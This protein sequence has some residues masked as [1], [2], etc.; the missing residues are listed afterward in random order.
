MPPLTLEQAKAISRWE[1]LYY[2]RVSRKGGYGPPEPFGVTVRAKVKTWK[3]QPSKVVIPVRDYN[4]RWY[5][6]PPLDEIG[7]ANKRTCTELT[8]ADLPFL[9]TDLNEAKLALKKRLE[10][11]WDKTKAEMVGRYKAAKE[12]A[13]RAFNEELERKKRLEE[14][15]NS[16]LAE[17]A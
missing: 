6:D 15:W 3:R 12:N 7:V 8:E 11:D 5:A 13:L 1:T 2:T 16:L 17:E 14:A 4:L 9:Y 10:N